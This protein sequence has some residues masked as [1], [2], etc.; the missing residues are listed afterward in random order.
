M[1]GSNFMAQGKDADEVM[2]KAGE[3][4]KRD[5]GMASIPPDVERE[6]RGAIREAGTRKAVSRGD[7]IAR[8]TRV[9]LPRFGRHRAYVVM[10]HDTRPREHVTSGASRIAVGASRPPPILALRFLP[11]PAVVHQSN[12]P[13]DDL[14]T[15][16]GVLH[17]RALE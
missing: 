15:V 5:H 9:D 14:V 2:Q 16:L 13:L 8:A 1:P 6:V 10:G 17:G 7:S 3:F 11:D 4:A 12:L